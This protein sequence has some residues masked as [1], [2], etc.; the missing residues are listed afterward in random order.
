MAFREVEFVIAHYNEDLLWLEPIADSCLIYTKGGADHTRPAYPFIPLPNIGREGHTYLWHIVKRYHSLA[1]VSVFL[2]GRIDDHVSIT[3]EEI[4]DRAH[5]TRPG[6]VTTFPFRELE[7]FDC[8][9]GI[10]WQ[11]YPCWRKWSAMD[12]KRMKKR[13][14]QY[15]RELFHCRE[16]PDSIAF[17]PGALFAVHRDTIQQYPRAFYRHLLR[18]FF[19]GDMAHVNP[20]TGHYMERFWLAMWRP[21]EYIC[22]DNE[23]DISEEERNSQGQLAKGRWLRTPKWV[24]VDER[25]VCKAGVG[26]RQ[27]EELR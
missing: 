15:F 8:W 4:K 25:T 22:W 6:E 3:P 5:R 12:C 21:D 14:G 13:P 17:Q 10:P 24:E 20:E 7:L 1:D 11:D 23:K 9:D 26:G 19:E 27:I 16:L 2:Q 18:E